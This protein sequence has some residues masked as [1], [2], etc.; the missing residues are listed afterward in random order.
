MCIDGDMFKQLWLEYLVDNKDLAVE[1]ICMLDQIRDKICNILGVH[2]DSIKGKC[3][4]TIFNGVDV[5]P[6]EDTKDDKYWA[7]ASKLLSSTTKNGYESMRST[8]INE[9][10]L[11]SKSIP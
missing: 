5:V 4:D 1:V 7:I 10:D 9:M 3:D 8:L 11:L 6:E 2:I